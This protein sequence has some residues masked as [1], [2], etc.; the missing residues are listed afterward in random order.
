[1]TVAQKLNQGI[2]RKWGV[3]IFGCLFFDTFLDNLSRLAGSKKV[4]NKIIIPQ[5]AD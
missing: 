1:M 4:R 3:I 5:L 2:H